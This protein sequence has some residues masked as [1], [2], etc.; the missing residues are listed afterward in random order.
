[1]SGVTRFRLNGDYRDVDDLFQLAYVYVKQYEKNKKDNKK[2]R[3]TYK[4]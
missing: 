1:M 3:L 4:G 2:K